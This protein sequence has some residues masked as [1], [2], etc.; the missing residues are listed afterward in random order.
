MNPN[1]SILPIAFVTLLVACSQQS[2]GERCLIANGNADCASGLV[3]T[4]PEDL[5]VERNSK[6]QTY[7]CCPSDTKAWTDARC[8][9]TS[10]SDDTTTTPTTG[11]AGAAGATGNAAKG[12]GGGMSSAG[13]S[14]DSAGTAGVMSETAGAAGAG[15]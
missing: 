10:S 1:R 8:Q 13:A 15:I 12:G 3:C 2:E 6:Y 11:T 9:T 4:A 7:R 14:G 5:E